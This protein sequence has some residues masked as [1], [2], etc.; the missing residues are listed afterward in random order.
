MRR[1][2]AC[3]GL[4]RKSSGSRKRLTWRVP[5]RR[6][7]PSPV[8]ALVDVLVNPDEPPMPGKVE[9][10]Q[11][12]GFVKAFLSGQPRKATI[13]STLFRD[14]VTEMR[15]VR[16]AAQV[17]SERTRN[18]SIGRTVWS[19]SIVFCTVQL[20]QSH[21]VDPG[22]FSLSVIGGGTPDAEHQRPPP[23]I[24]CRSDQADRDLLR[25]SV[26]S[27]AAWLDPRRPESHR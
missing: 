7:S 15:A 5:S 13:A 25:C 21:D 1:G 19:V 8:P 2:L 6:R 14:K 4:R 3:R 16:V 27:T 17:R 24:G 10:E 12:K 11:A 22:R 26:P 23:P 20:P 9:Y 18:G